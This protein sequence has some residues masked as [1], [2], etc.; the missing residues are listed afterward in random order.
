MSYD[1]GS[2]TAPDINDLDLLNEPVEVDGSVNS[3][4]FFTPQLPDDGD[5][6]V[7]IALGDRGIKVARQKDKATG[8]RTG[9][10]FL[11]VHLAL[12]LVDDAGNKQGMVFDNPTSVVFSSGTSPLHV[13]LDL[14]GDPAPASS[15][16]GELKAHAE[17]VF[18]QNPKIV[19]TTQWLAQ[20]KNA[21]GEYQ[22]VKKGQKNFPL[23]ENGKYSPEITVPKTG[24]TVNAQAKVVRYKRVS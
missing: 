1:N 22:D 5:H 18:A 15:T 11:N 9:K 20:V 13:I 8:N 4:E 12:T 21:N 7:T 16:L 23:L 19:V 17:L 3:D 6:L 2:A 10:G 14:A 24:E